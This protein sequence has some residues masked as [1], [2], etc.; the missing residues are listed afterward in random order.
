MQPLPDYSAGFDLP[1][2]FAN[3]PQPIMTPRTLWFNSFD[4]N[5]PLFSTISNAND[6]A[7]ALP[8]FWQGQEP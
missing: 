2:D 8:N 6:F 5:M 3:T 4:E 7:G 1:D